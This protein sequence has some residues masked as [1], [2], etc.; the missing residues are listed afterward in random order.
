VP[1]GSIGFRRSR[2]GSYSYFD[3]DDAVAE[4]FFGQLPPMPSG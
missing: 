3:R 4:S 2:K 1:E